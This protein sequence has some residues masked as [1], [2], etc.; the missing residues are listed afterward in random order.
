MK[1]NVDEEVIRD[2]PDEARDCVENR[3][4][5]ILCRETVS[6]LTH[7]RPENI[8]L[9]S[10][11]SSCVSPRTRLVSLSSSILDSERLVFSRIDIVSNESTV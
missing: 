3:W 6:A 8:R 10:R 5:D 2:C 1:I 7:L 11:S 4:V 9:T